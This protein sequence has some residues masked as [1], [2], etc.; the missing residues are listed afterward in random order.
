MKIELFLKNRFTLRQQKS[1]T[2]QEEVFFSFICMQS[3]R[4]NVSVRVGYL[5]NWYCNFFSLH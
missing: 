2:L 5:Y 3:E 4:M 1:G